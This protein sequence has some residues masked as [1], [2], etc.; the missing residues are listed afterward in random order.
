MSSG[1][2]WLQFPFVAHIL[3]KAPHS[4]RTDKECIGSLLEGSTGIFL[5]VS[6]QGFVSLVGAAFRG[7][8]SFFIFFHL[9]SSFF[10]FFDTASDYMK[11][12]KLD[13]IE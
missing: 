13:F 4:G 8:S 6:Q 9:F 11:L 12:A 2:E 7:F 5:Q 10:I 1:G 3:H